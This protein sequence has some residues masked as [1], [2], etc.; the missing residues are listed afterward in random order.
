VR[1]GELAAAQWHDWVN[2]ER[3]VLLQAIAQAAS[4]GLITHAWRIFVYEGLQ[5]LG[6]GYWADWRD[7]GQAVLAAAEAA[8]DHTGLGWA[9]AIIGQHAALAGAYDQGRVHLAQALDHFRQA[10]DLP[11]QAWVLFYL[12]RPDTRNAAWAEAAALCEQSLAL[13]RRAGDQGGGERWALVGLGTCHAHLGNYELARGYARQ[14]LELDPEGS[15]PIHQARTY[16][17]LGLVHSR[18]GEH[19][20]AISAYQQ[21]LDAAPA[22][23]APLSR[24]VL[25]GLLAN[26]GDACQAAGDPAA[27]RQTWQQALQVLHDL[28][29]PDNRRIR[30][31]LELASQPG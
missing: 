30:A 8:G 15:D 12:A 7:A 9:H 6:E 13:F 19:R 3:Q 25:A 28:G 10:D 5:D 31:K 22:W 26:F 14:A 2:A 1:G 27:A 23:K 4:A 16:G 17:L 20:Q 29:L 11:G 21:A 24:R 18:Q